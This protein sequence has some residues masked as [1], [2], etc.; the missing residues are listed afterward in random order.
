MTDLPHYA[1][2]R[3]GDLVRQRGPGIFRPY[4]WALIIAIGLATDP[5]GLWFAPEC[6]EDCG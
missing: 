4:L 2:L 5:L 6:V 1:N 3:D